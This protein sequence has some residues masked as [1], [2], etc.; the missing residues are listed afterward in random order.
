MDFTNTI[1]V[2]TTNVGEQAPAGLPIG[3]GAGAGETRGSCDAQVAAARRALPPEL[4][5]RIDEPLYFAPLSRSDVAKIARRMLDKLGETLLGERGVLLEVE[6]SAIETLIEVGGYDPEL[7]ARPMRR[8]LGRHVEAPLA[9]MVLAGELAPG[10]VARLVGDGERI[11]I[12]LLG[13]AEA[14]E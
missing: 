3:F 6:P 11:S 4:W 8:V 7:G 13:S 5:N 2:M 9:S 14:A 12:E 1:V 10:D